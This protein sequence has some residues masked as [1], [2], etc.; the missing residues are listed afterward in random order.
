MLFFDVAGVRLL[1]GSEN[2]EGEPGGSI[3]YFD[4]PDI[5]A[6]ASALESRGVNF[7][8]PAQVVQRT[9]SHNLTI[10]AFRDPDGNTLQLMGM[11][12]R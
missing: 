3:L 7:H 6:L 5:G 10:R 4:A 12:K 1:I 11:V 8:G 2:P 9:E